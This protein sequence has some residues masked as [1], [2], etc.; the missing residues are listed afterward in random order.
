[1]RNALEVRYVDGRNHALDIVSSWVKAAKKRK[2]KRI[3]DADILNII[4]DRYL[5]E[6]NLESFDSGYFNDYN[7]NIGPIP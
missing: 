3:T 6:E 7:S 4:M 2:R 1:M 5:L